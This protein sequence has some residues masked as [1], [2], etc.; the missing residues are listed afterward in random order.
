MKHSFFAL[1]AVLL[2][3]A[4]SEPARQFNIS[5]KLSFYYSHHRDTIHFDSLAVLEIRDRDNLN[6]Y[7]D[8]ALSYQLNS[9][10]YRML[11]SSPNPASGDLA[12]EVIIGNDTVNFFSVE[13]GFS[14][15]YIEVTPVDAI[16]NSLEEEINRVGHLSTLVTY[17]LDNAPIDFTIDVQMD[18]TVAVEFDL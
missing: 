2:I 16:I 12:F 15:D 6:D 1:I 18:I 17:D 4:C 9:V 5:K 11:V 13:S 8:Y 3:S 7:S 10:A 14:N